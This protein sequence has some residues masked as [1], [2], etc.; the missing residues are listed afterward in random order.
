MQVTKGTEEVHRLR[1]SHGSV[2]PG[3]GH[4]SE[5]TTP[6]EYTDLGHSI[7]LSRPTRFS[8]SGIMSPPGLTN[9]S[10]RA[11]SQVTSNMTERDRTYLALTS[12]APSHSFPGSHRDSDEDEGNYEATTKGFNT[13]NT[14]S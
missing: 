1:N 12:E 13:Y 4:Q 2:H 5:P 14:A 8:T 3:A 9:R 7:S 6:P 11:D 10:S